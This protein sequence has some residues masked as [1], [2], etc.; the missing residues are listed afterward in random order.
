[1]IHANNSTFQAFLVAIVFVVALLYWID[2]RRRA[3]REQ[4]EFFEIQ[5][6]AERRLSAK[7]AV[8]HATG[9]RGGADRAIESAWERSNDAR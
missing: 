1:M 8:V 7:H 6:A 5:K 2:Y 3:R 9:R 4:L